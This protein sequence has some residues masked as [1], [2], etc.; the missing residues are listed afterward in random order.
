MESQIPQTAYPHLASVLSTPHGMGTLYASPP[1]GMSILD[2]TRFPIPGMFW[3][4]TN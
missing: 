2:P 1:Y 4:D 3:T